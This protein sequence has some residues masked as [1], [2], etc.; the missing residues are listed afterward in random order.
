M[1]DPAI[2]NRRSAGDLPRLNTSVS[3]MNPASTSTATSSQPAST[4]R[5][6]RRADAGGI[7]FPRAARR[8]FSPTAGTYRAPSPSSSPSGEPPLRAW[9]GPGPA[10]RSPF[11]AAAPHR[12]SIASA[13]ASA[14]IASGLAITFRLIGGDINHCIDRL[15]FCPFCP[16]SAATPDRPAAEPPIDRSP[17][18]RSG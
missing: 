12:Q 9:P 1:P 11:P 5:T 8:S 3:A 10:A 7:A 15:L 16:P 18:P 2:E 6:I 4:G 14:S 13:W 17:G